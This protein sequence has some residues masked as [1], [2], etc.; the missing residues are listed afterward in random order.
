MYIYDINMV[1]DI[2]DGN[3]FWCEMDNTSINCLLQLGNEELHYRRK[4]IPSTVHDG[5]TIKW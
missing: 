1:K 2:D 4:D 5:N 3:F